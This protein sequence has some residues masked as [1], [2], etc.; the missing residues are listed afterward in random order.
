MASESPKITKLTKEQR[1]VNDAI[2]MRER[3]SG[4]LKRE[5][6]KIVNRHE[7]A[8]PHV[9]LFLTSNG[10]TV[11]SEVKKT[12][13]SRDTQAR[14]TKKAKAA[15]KKKAA[16]EEAKANADKIAKFESLGD[17]KHA[18][19]AERVLPAI[20]PRLLSSANVKAMHAKRTAAKVLVDD[21]LKLIEFFT[22]EP[23]SMPLTGSCSTWSG[24]GSW[25]KARSD[26]RS[27]LSAE[28]ALPIDFGVDG[29]YKVAK[30]LESEKA[31]LIK[32][33]YNGKSIKIG[34]AEFSVEPS[35]L[36]SVTVCSNHSEMMAALKYRDAKNK[37]HMARLTTWFS[38]QL[39]GKKR[40]LNADVS[41]GS[42]KKGRSSSSGSP[43]GKSPRSV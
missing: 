1:K 35:D 18:L 22:G 33:Q 30:V 24:L 5:I 20:H 10:W 41:P 17:I 40:A 12:V 42:S 21:Y 16:A 2:M 43:N 8:R 25:L 37:I 31:L 23:P 27:R 28:Q 36:S 4:A 26:E 7:D 3:N 19:L 39:A 9:H 13:K 6:N 11:D 14:E 34:A 29:I 38:N 15:A 32:H